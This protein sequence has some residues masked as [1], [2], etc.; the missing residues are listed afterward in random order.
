MADHLR[1]E[2]AEFESGYGANLDQ[3]RAA[4]DAYRV[5]RTIRDQELTTMRNA[6]VTGFAESAIQVVQPR[7]SI[8]LALRFPGW[9]DSYRCFRD[10]LHHTGIS[11]FPGIL[12]FCFSGSY[13]RVTTTR[14]W[15]DLS[16]AMSRLAS[17]P[18]PDRRGL[19]VAGHDLP[20][21]RTGRGPAHRRG[22]DGA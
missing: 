16:A 14:R 12:T 6:S 22:G 1:T 10:L 2:L 13:V 15:A 7:Y 18:A 17:M 5:D 4:Y 19:P 20:P 21:P 8:N 11:V 9:D 3:L